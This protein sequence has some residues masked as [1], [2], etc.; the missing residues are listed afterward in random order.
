M[1]RVIR[2]NINVDTSHPHN[3]PLQRDKKLALIKCNKNYLSE[4][5]P[6]NVITRF[7]FE[8]KKLRSFPPI[9]PT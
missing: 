6:E 4:N 3:S 7:T 8:G 1:D 5:L 9:N 2:V